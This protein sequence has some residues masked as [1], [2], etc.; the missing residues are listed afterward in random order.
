MHK[1]LSTWDTYRYNLTSS[2]L[3]EKHNSIRTGCVFD[4]SPHFSGRKFGCLSYRALGCTWPLPGSW[5]STGF[6]ENPS[7]SET[8][9]LRPG[10]VRAPLAPCSCGSDCGGESP[11]AGRSALR[12]GAPSTETD[13]QLRPPWLSQRSL[14][15]SRR[16][17]SVFF[18]TQLDKPP[19]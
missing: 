19:K 12:D 17:L 16:S 13:Q 4:K 15:H 2:L 3:C 1:S 18:C 8:C 11:G 14:L 10:A 5:C 9:Q 6:L 7:G